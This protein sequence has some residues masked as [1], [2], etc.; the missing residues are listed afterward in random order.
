ML[1]ARFNIYTLHTIY[2]KCSNTWEKRFMGSELC[3]KASFWSSILQNIEESA[4]SS[5]FSTSTL[6][7]NAVDIKNIFFNFLKIKGKTEF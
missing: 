4:F 1:V 6:A 3:Y 5:E 7:T 2:M